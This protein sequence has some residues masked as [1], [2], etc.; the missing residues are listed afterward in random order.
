VLVEAETPNAG[1]VI[2]TRGNEHFVKP[3]YMAAIAGNVQSGGK[4]AAYQ[5]AL[6]AGFAETARGPAGSGGLPH[7]LRHAADEVTILAAVADEITKPAGK[8]E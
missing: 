1:R 8:S 3:V 4:G 7:G 5:P 6:F 2:F